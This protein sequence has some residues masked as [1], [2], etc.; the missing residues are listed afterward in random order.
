MDLGG[1]E[2]H[3]LS[4]ILKLLGCEH[5]K[6]VLLY[7]PDVVKRAKLFLAIENVPDQSDIA[8]RRHPG[9]NSEEQRGRYNH[10][11]KFICNFYRRW[12]SKSCGKLSLSSC[13]TWQIYYC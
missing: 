3:F 10:C 8:E 13:C 4:Q 5:I 9:W 7:F 6:G 12:D 1:G 11:E 2:G